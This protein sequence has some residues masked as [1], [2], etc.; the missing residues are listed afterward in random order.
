M[1]SKS[2]HI[3]HIC[4]V[5]GHGNLLVEM[6]GKNINNVEVQIIEGAR[7]FE[8]FAVGRKY[9][10]A[11]NIM[12]RICAICSSSHQL[13]AVEALERS[14]NIVPSDQVYEFRKLLD[15]GENMQSHILHVG[16]LA[17]PDFLGYDG[18]IQMV[19]EYPNEVK[20]VLRMKRIAND[21]QA[22][23]GGREIHPVN[24]TPGGFGKYPTTQQLEEM[25]EK[26]I[27]FKKGTQAIA[28][29]FAKLK[30]PDFENKTEQV[31]VYDG[32]TYPFLR[33][34]MKCLL[35]G[36]KVKPEDYK[37]NFITEEVR[38]Y[39]TAKFSTIN[40]GEV[41]YVSPLARVNINHEFLTDDAKAIMNQF[42]MKLPNFNPF[43]NN[44][45]RV[46]ELMQSVDEAI[47]I[48][49]KYISKPPKEDNKKFTVKPGTGSVATE[50]P[51]G[52]LNHSY[53]VDK[54]G[55]I[56]RADVIT[57]TAHNVNKI[58]NDVKKM[59][60]MLNGKKEKE[61]ELLLNILVRSYDPCISCS[62][63]A[64]KIHLKK[65]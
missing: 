41:Y 63:H 19:P 24:I 61:A 9:N 44:L 58:E 8:G 10:E 50:A 52:L 3:E 62:A 30:M 65:I 15:H 20:L 1:T 60:E 47:E 4:R 40:N 17:L 59:G 16:M 49:E 22:L 12:S 54:N 38:Q 33:G 45:A 46:I 35:S 29:L 64:L 55:I 11:I 56:Q 42:N 27:E 25:K 39:S 32:K 36:K 26:L 51:R 28:D 18:A 6:D 2:Y 31:A 13:S 23:I 14:V 48:T 34:D 21:L 5:E 7:F 53:D 57:P 37:K 43:N